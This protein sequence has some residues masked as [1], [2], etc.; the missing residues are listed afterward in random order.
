MRVCVCICAFLDISRHWKKCD[1][2][3]YCANEKKNF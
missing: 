3:N 1:V 2:K